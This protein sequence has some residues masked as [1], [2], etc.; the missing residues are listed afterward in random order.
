MTETEN[1]NKEIIKREEN[2]MQDPTRAAIT[3]DR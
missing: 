3:R 1:I 2:N